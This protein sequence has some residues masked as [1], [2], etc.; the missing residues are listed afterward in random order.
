MGDT[1]QKGEGFI[2][3]SGFELA[4]THALDCHGEKFTDF[5]R[6]L[7]CAA[8]LMKTIHAKIVAFFNSYAI[9]LPEKYRCLENGTNR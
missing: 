3:P 1:I 2:E 6:I 9:M 7:S 8:V 4:R 5:K